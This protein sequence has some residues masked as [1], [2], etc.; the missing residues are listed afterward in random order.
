M[1]LLTKTLEARIPPLYATDGVAFDAKTIVAKFFDPCGSWTWYV[2]EG[3]RQEDGSF[4]CFG[5]V[6][7]PERE[8]GY[9]NVAELETVKGPLGIGIERDLHWEARTLTKA[10]LEGEEPFAQQCTGW[11]AHQEALRAEAKSKG[12]L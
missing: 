9:F 3:E 7:G 10:E 5:L 6:D 8:W 2:A 1:Q 4:L 11:L 12:A